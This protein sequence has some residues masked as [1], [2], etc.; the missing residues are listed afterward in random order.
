MDAKENA[1]HMLFL[2]MCITLRGAYKVTSNLEAG[3]GRSDITLESLNPANSHVI[4]EFKQGED[5]ERLKE[6]ALEQI[7]AQKYY[8][9]LNGEVICIGLAHDKK[10]CQM[11][12][13]TMTI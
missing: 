3:Y 1:Y 4:I 5:L 9:G 12:Y 7:T 13:K 8:A 10:R 11:V 2:G 6:E